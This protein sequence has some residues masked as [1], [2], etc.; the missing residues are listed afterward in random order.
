MNLLLL[1]KDDFLNKSTVRIRGRQH[2]HV[3][4]ILKSKVGDTISVGLLDGKI[5]EGTITQ[6][7]KKS[8]EMKISLKNNPPKP[9][10]VTLILALPRPP[11]LKRVFISASS[12]GIKKIIL[13][14]FNKVEKSFWQSSSLKDHAIKE[15][16]ILG[17]E[18]ARDTI[19]P[20]VILKKRFKPFVEDE[21][22]RII[23]GTLPIVAHPEAKKKCPRSVKKPVTLIVGPEGGL[24]PYEFEKLKTIG[25][26]G[27]NLGERI[28]R[29][30][31]FIPTIISKLF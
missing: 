9:L 4:K 7:D 8:L 26:S 18:Q 31:T 5:G 23:K 3:I 17:L 28:L 12:L 27:V 30:E 15:Q 11:V 19:M 29:V 14:Q 24:I 16:L 1:N 25:F 22:P 20:E 21:L 13:L 6:L 10:P 2:L